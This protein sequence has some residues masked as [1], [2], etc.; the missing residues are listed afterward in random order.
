[1]SYPSSSPILS[2]MDTPPLAIAQKTD[3]QGVVAGG[4]SLGMP[5][6]SRG[7]SSMDID[8]TDSLSMEWEIDKRRHVDG[9]ALARC[10][11]G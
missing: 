3:Y 11:W 8:V 2:L 4:P 6:D 5:S 9:D 10:R 7:F 1:M